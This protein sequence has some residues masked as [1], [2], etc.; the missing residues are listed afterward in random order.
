MSKGK[1]NSVPSYYMI[2]NS[3]GEW[4]STGI[5]NFYSRLLRVHIVVPKGE[6]C[7]LASIPKPLRML[8]A[9]NG[10]HRPAASLHD[11]LYRVKGL[12]SCGRTL[13][14]KECDLVF[15]EAMSASR[16]SYFK[17]LPSHYREML[18]HEGKDDYF[19]ENKP[20]VKAITCNLMHSGVRAGGVFY[21]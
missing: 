8:F 18:I 13:T 16:Q 11:Y 12:L 19:E 3:K 21:W 1:F 7:N 6:V 5:L 17:A 10:P 9:V 4:L 14:R 20:L 15:K 2:P